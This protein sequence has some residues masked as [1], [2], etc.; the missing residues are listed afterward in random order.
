M[1]IICLHITSITSSSLFLA[2]G[3]LLLLLLLPE[4]TSDGAAQITKASH[5][6]IHSLSEKVREHEREIE[7]G[8]S[9]RARRQR[10]GERA[11]ERESEREQTSP[12]LPRMF[13]VSVDYGTQQ[14][15]DVY[16]Q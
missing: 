5:H 4:H 16:C 7:K 12:A 14:H 10:Q 2:G 8:E 9:G 3:T 13:I 6:V 15:T 1:C 11:R